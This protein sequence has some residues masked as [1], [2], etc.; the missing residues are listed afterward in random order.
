[1]HSTLVCALLLRRLLPRGRCRLSQS[2]TVSSW[3]ETYS[4]RLSLTSF[5][6]RSAQNYGKTL[7]ASAGTVSLPM[8]SLL[9]I[10][11]SHWARALWMQPRNSHASS[12]TRLARSAVLSKPFLVLVICMSQQLMQVLHLTSIMH[13]G[14]AEFSSGCISILAAQEALTHLHVDRG[15]KSR[16]RPHHP[17]STSID[18]SAPELNCVAMGF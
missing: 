5:L 16:H 12:M 3:Q 6:M 18:T 8:P 4:I 9:D 10:D 13:A 1:M 7:C 2:G 17:D 11:F 14:K 15:W